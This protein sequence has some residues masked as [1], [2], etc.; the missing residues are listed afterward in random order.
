MKINTNKT[1]S[2]ELLEAIEMGNVA[3]VKFLLDQ[4][5]EVNYRENLI[6]RWFRSSPTPLGYAVERGSAEI[7]KLLIDVGADV[8]GIT[9][10][11][12]TPL[13]IAAYKG[14]LDIVRLLLENGAD[15]N[16]KVVPES[17]NALQQAAYYG[18]KEIAKILLE[19]GADPQEVMKGG[20]PSLIR[21][22][23]SILELLREAGGEVP[24]EIVELLETET[25][26]K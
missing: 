15:V 14:Y 1:S 11:C 18:H 19:Y 12:T 8:N 25:A 16:K 5:V 24:P 20:I 4:G 2:K 6:S 23:G 17:A 10:G 21:I 13:I 26:L 7:V 22:R 9:R 3:K